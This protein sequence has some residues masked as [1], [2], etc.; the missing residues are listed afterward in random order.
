MHVCTIQLK[1]TEHPSAFLNLKPRWSHHA[2]NVRSA[3]R[4]D[5]IPLIQ[6]FALLVRFAR[7]V[8]T[9]TMDAAPCL[10]TSLQSICWAIRSIHT[11]VAWLFS[12]ASLISNHEQAS[13]YLNGLICL[14]LIMQILLNDSKINSDLTWALLSSLRWH[15]PF[16]CF[17]FQ[18]FA[19]SPI[20]SLSGRVFV[21][22]KNGYPLRS[23]KR[24]YSIR[25]QIFIVKRT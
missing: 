5:D 8:F 21:K 22:E 17:L 10:H 12:S 7:R 13:C 14:A 11:S 1:L 25:K 3:C 19:I 18:L 9:C 24:K 4:W 6:I 16:L 2:V 15:W 23:I 20:Y